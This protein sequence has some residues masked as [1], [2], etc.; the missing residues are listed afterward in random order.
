MTRPKKHL[1]AAKALRAHY[2]A[3]CEAVGDCLIWTGALDPSGN[4]VCDDTT[5]RRVLWEKERGP[6]PKGMRALCSCEDKRCIA[7]AHMV[8]KS[9]SEACKAAIQRG[10]YG[11]AQRKAISTKVVRARETT[12][13]SL[14]A[15]R[16]IRSS[17][18]SG[19]A[20]A[21]KFGC[22]ATA[23]SLA[24]RGVTWREAANGASVFSWG[25]VAA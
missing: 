12:K 19:R 21:R 11:V 7:R 14:E 8:L 18:L 16:E 22:S 1:A 13:L 17:P 2:E 20:L 9:H 4:P 3:R 5:I 23:I 15:V 25:G 24:R 6:I 10:A